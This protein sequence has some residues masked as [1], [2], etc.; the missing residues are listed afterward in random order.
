M[1]ED[2]ID[3]LVNIIGLSCDG[4]TGVQSN[5]LCGMY[6]A[7]STWIL[8]KYWYPKAYKRWRDILRE[9]FINNQ[10]WLIMNCTLEEYLTQAWNGGVF[11]SEP[12]QEVIDEFVE[13]TGID[14]QIA[15][16]YFNKK[17]C[18]CDKRIKHKEVLSMNLK[19]H[20]RQV[21]KFYCKKCLMKEFN[22]TQED[23]NR[24]VESFKAQGC[25]LF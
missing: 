5:G 4:L 7:K 1:N 22:W 17:C 12:T 21:N 14:K 25:A 23:W 16:Q 2:T 20:G 10:K 19:I 9:D 18:G 13:H 8:D 15:L 6:C 11:R 3:E 24:Q